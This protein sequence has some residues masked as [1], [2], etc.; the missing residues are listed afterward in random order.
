[1]W[2]K[3]KRILIYPDGVTE[4]QVYPAWWKPWANTIAYYP[5][6][7]TSTV[8]DMSGNSRNL[9]NNW[10]LFGTY[11]WVDC[12]YFDNTNSK[13]LYWTLPLT[14]NQTFTVNV[15][16]QRKWWIYTNDNPNI[17]TLG[18]IWTTWRCFWVWAEWNNY[19]Y[20]FYTRG[21]DWISTTVNTLDTWE[22]L[23]VTNDGSK[24]TLYKNT[25][26]ILQQSVTLDVNDTKFTIGSFPTMASWNG[27]WYRYNWYM[28]Q[29]IVEN[30]AWTADQIAW[31]YN[32]TKSLYWLS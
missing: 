21:T 28:S 29:F 27:S 22:M 13:K 15:Y 23:T 7:S 3:L 30:R 25:T 5:L 8:N 14:W 16:V 18:S 12:A 31:Y 4:K 20:Q 11:G 2:Y 17:F 19:Y 1:M 6:T 26:Q 10:T 24:I 32:Q 9:T